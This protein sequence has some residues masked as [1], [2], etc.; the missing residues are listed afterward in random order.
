MRC[1]IYLTFYFVATLCLLFICIFI[2]IYLHSFVFI[3]IK[4]GEGEMAIGPFH[5]NIN[6]R[7]I[8]KWN[9]FYRLSSPCC[10]ILL[11]VPIGAKLIGPHGGLQVYKQAVSCVPGSMEW[12]HYILKFF[13]F[14][15]RWS[16]FMLILNNYKYK[17]FQSWLFAESNQ[18]LWKTTANR[19]GPV[20]I[21]LGL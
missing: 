18:G 5:E 19:P 10:L 1:S 15:I 12:P 20:K 2:C 4:A 9:S 16:I 7:N 17:T 14:E 11:L 3:K 21:L 8:S 6:L 13:L